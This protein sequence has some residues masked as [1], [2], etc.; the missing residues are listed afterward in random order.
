[1]SNSDRVIKYGQNSET[2]ST[3]NIL[4]SGICKQK[5]CYFIIGSIIALIIVVVIIVVIILTT[6]KVT[7][8]PEEKTEVPTSLPIEPIKPITPTEFEKQKLGSEFDFNTKEGDLKRILV[9]QKYTEDRII[10]GE[11][12]TTFFSRNTIYDIYIISEQNSDEENKYYYDKLYTCALSIQKECHSSTNENCEPKLKVDLSKVASRNLEKKRN[13]EEKNNLKDLPIPICLFNLTNND[14][15]TSISCHKSLPETKKKMIVLDLYFFRPPGIKRLKKENIDDTITR[16]T[17]NNRKYIREIN[18]GICDI[19]NA[20]FS[21]CTT[22]MNTTTDLENNILSYDEKAIMNITVDSDN[23]YVKTKITNLVDISDKVE[24]FNPKIYEEN[25]NNIIKKIKPFLKNDVLFSKENFEEIYFIS[26]NGMEAFKKMQKRKLL[27][28]VSQEDNMIKKENNLLD[29]FSP[30]SGITVDVT[31]FNNAGINSDFM[32]ADSKFYIEHNKTEDISTTKE[33]SRSFNQIIKDLIILSKSGNHLATELYKKTNITLEEMTEEINKAIS[34]LNDLIMYKDLSEIFDSTLSLDTIKTLPFTIIQE[35]TTLKKKLEEILNNIENNGIKQNIKILNQNI[36]TYIEESRNII[37]GLFNNLRELSSSLSSSKSKLTE[38]STYYLNHTSTSYIST[39]E[40]AKNILINYYKDEYNLISPKIDLLLKKFEEKINESVEKE[41]K[42]IDNLYEKIENGNFSIKQSNDEEIKVILNNL[43]YTK[44][45]LKEL[46]EKISAKI[47]KEMDIK[48]NGYFISDYDLNSNYGTFSSIIEKASKISNELDKDEFIDTNFDEVMKNIKKNFTE[49]IKYMDKQ[50]E[51]LFPLNEDVLKGSSFTLEFQNEMKNSITE[52]GVDILNKI[53][54]ENDYYLEAK[55]RIVDEFLSKNKEDLNNLVLELDNIFSAVK[56][57]ELANLYEKAFNSSLDKTKNEINKNKLLS[58]EYF[59]TLAEDDKIKELLKNF[60][61]DEQHLPYCISRVPYHEIYFTKFVDQI[62]SKAKTS[63]YLSKYNIYKDNL[64]KSKLYVNEQLY[65]DLLSE[66]KNFMSKIREILQ[67]FKNNKMSD[68]Y[69]DLNEL[70]FL[71]E[72]IRIVDNF[73]NRLNNYISDDIFNKKYIPIMNDFKD[74]QNKEIIN[75]TNN[76]ELNH[77]IINSYPLKNDYNYDFCVSF[78]RKKTYTC[79]NGAVFLY[80]NSDYYCLPASSVSNNFMNLTEH[81]IDSDVGI[82]QFRSKFK[83]FN[84]TLCE[85]INLYSSKI[86]E[87]KQSLID[88]ET[89][90]INKD[91]TLNYL[92]PIKESINTLLSN[93]YG[94]KIIQSSYNY[95]QP[96]IKER[97]EPLLNDI[98]SLWNQSFNDLYTDIE[99][100]LHDFKNSIMELSN[101]AGFYLSILNSNITKNYF[102]SIDLH[103]KTEFNYTITYY[104]NILLKLVKSSHQY[105][106]SKLPSN[107]IGFN[108]IINIREKEINDIFNNLIKKIEESQNEALNF[109]Q[110]LYVLQ[111]PETNFFDVNNILRD[112]VQTTEKNLNSKLAEIRKLKNSKF[113]DEFS[114][115]ARFYLENSESGKQ[116]EELYEQINEKVFVYLNLEKFKELLIE[117]WIFDQDEFIKNLKN[118]LYNS[119]LEVEKELNTEKGKFMKSLEEEITKTYTKDQVAIMINN[120]YKNEIKDLELNQINDIRQNI[121]DILY[122]I[123]QEFTE[124]TK[125]LKETSNSYNKDYSKIEKRIKNY[126][127]EI[128]EKIKK[129]IFS[130]IN[131]FH[132]NINTKIYTNYYES[133]LNDYMSEAQKTTSNFGKI[134]LLSASYDVGEIINNIIKNLCKNYKTYVKNEIDFNY[135]NSYL[136]IKNKVEFEKLE[137]LINEQID[138]SYNSI[139]L[140][141]LKEVATNEIGIE[142]YNPYDLGDNI[143]NNINEIITTKTNN[144]KDIIE[145][146]KGTNFEI[147]IKKWKKMDFS[148]VYDII[149]QNCRTLAT[150]ISSE[151]DNEKEQVDIFLKETMIS[152]FNDL[153]QNIIPSFGNK[154]FERIIKYNENFKISSLYN[155][156][157]YSLISTMTYYLSL[158]GSSKIKALTKDLKLK[159][160]SLNNLDLIAENKNKE[161]LELL[162]QKINE[163]IQDSQEF[164][165]TKYLAFFKNDVSIEQS[166]NG[167]VR[168]EII[169]NLYNLEDTFRDDYLNIMNDY[170]KDKLITSY[171]KVMNQKTAEMIQSVVEKRESLKSKLDDLFSLEPDEVLTEIN[172]K[173]NNTLASIDRYNSHFNSFKISENL[174]DFLNNFGK[175]NILPK[176]DGVMSI[177]NSETKD[178]IIKTIDKNSLDYKNYFSTEEFTK[179][180]DNSY[181]KIQNKYIQS[182]NSSIDKYGKE[183]YPNNLEKEIGRQTI[184][185]RRRLEH[186]LT[187]EEIENEYKEKIADKA[188]DDTFSKI[189]TSSNNAKRFI[190]TFEKFDDFDKSMNE[191]INKLNIAYKHSLKIIKD[192]DYTEEVYNTLT[193]KLSELKNLTLDYYTNINNSFFELKNNLKKSI[194]D[195]NNDLN[196]C[197]NITYTTFAEKYENLS[198]VEK[199]DSTID[200]KIDQI[201]D[202]K[203]IDNQN[204]ITKVNYTIS[205]I[206]QKT[207]FKFDLEFEEGEIRKPRVKASVIN[208]SRP[209]NI[210]FKFISPQDGV[211]DIIERI[212]VETNNANFTMNIY[213][214]TSSKDLYVTT[215]TDFESYKY[216]KELIQLEENNIEKCD[217]EDGIKLCYEYY[218]YTEDNPKVLSSKRDTTIGRKT[219]VEE[220]IVHESKLFDLLEEDY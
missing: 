128:V 174:V 155:T 136:E 5:K 3:N 79:V 219:I 168:H 29:I 77:E 58:E 8:G 183:E 108:N 164:L 93:K 211:G 200:K 109:D 199:I 143:V 103:Q 177:L 22:D 123:K 94:D 69:P 126:K 11:K 65:P 145:S 18:R 86:Y 14:V 107:P 47:R 23:S 154:F 74:T 41:I 216:S 91:F 181:L 149:S 120:H 163:F 88:I 101:M 57:E 92:S 139:L 76:I 116:I 150:F 191:N 62:S 90:T 52:K 113:N 48:P 54:K 129:N 30:N 210:N 21:F 20:Q 40:K 42:I 214:S 159:I 82:S 197:A 51:E 87:F 204:K 140:V 43:Y 32:E 162:N 125:R 85:K 131:D 89:E 112:N 175:N 4:S 63:G 138:D 83:E 105:V 75:I 220:S 73:Y 84:D 212:N 146:T 180:T 202:T 53:R 217:W 37:I 194:N 56:L 172:N 66:Y 148:L 38:I 1:M 144:I 118:I 161:V 64:E 130:A 15:I 33:S 106:I 55:R 190:N 122:K 189:L 7:K 59:T 187:E 104:Y 206:I 98:S 68:K 102:N 173:I 99:N 39:I 19:E 12:V 100:K 46:V 10:D 132:Q 198:K 114:L 95:Y 17:V 16:K 158:H 195:I 205:N 127:I 135:N 44:N 24:N 167:I 170:L 72:H 27:D 207:Q 28:G 208:Q 25:L 165:V 67:V 50:K 124:E 156:L 96:N 80:D 78:V 157:K 178:N 134:D 152:N 6:K 137:N 193:S 117:N 26:K 196:H 179:T 201:S 36:Y 169:E 13:L 31:L 71:D 110:Q 61:T 119:N 171:T 186:K 60:H 133:N 9:N 34:I 2:S 192:N 218:D 209:G 185:I 111:V 151:G 141:S 153:L 166:F 215:I 184:R 176:F 147:D 121:N 49:I 70:S 81:S 35:S 182:I 97:I 115:S 160:Y 142:G 203:I 213:F 188:I 45:Y